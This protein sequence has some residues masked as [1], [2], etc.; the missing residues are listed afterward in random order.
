MA[1]ISN[2]SVRK[3]LT[4]EN[5]TGL[6]DKLDTLTASTIEVLNNL[7]S[8]E[9]GKAL[10]AAQ[11]KALKGLIDAVS[12]KVT[13][14][15][16]LVH[17]D[18]ADLDTI[19]EIVNKI[20]E[21]GT[22]LAGVTSAMD[23]KKS[24]AIAAAAQALQA[25]AT[26]LQS[27]IDAK[28]AKTDIV[29]NLVDGGSD[30]VLSAEQGKVLKGLIDGKTSVTVNN[31]LTSDAEGEALSAKQGKE[32]KTA[33]DTV[34]EKV[35]LFETVTKYFEVEFN[36]ESEKELANEFFKANSSVEYTFL[37]GDTQGHIVTYTDEG[38]IKIQST[39]PETGKFAVYVTNKVTA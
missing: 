20:K 26:E 19:Q 14:L 29:D 3:N 25:K 33:L 39:A 7:E 16:T 36:N 31:T 4:I 34:A 24:E 22:A 2:T 13:A 27:A 6:K 11:G 10:A 17:S 8:D 5:I 9:A 28:V 1:N 12:G 30:K 18:D 37:N 15:E 35:K 32:L 38:R 21:A 23:T